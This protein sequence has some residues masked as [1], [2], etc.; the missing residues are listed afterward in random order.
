MQLIHNAYDA[1]TV[2]VIL[3]AS[4]VA[5]DTFIFR[6]A[7]PFLSIPVD[8]A[9]SV[10]AFGSTDTTEAVQTIPGGTLM[11]GESYVAIASGEVDSM[12]FSVEVFTPARMMSAGDTLVDLLAFH[13]SPDAPQVLITAQDVGAIFDPISFKEF[14]SDYTS[15]PPASYLIDVN[16]AADTSLVAT[17]EADLSGLGGGAAT[18]FASGFVTPA[19]EMDP[20]FGLWATLAD[21]TTFPLAPFVPEPDSALVQ[22]IHNAPGADT[23]SVIL[24]ANTVAIDTFVFRTAT[25]FLSIPADSSISVVGF[26]ATDTTG[27]VFTIP[28]G[29]LMDD[30]S[31]VAI[32]AGALDS[33]NI[34]VEAFAPAKML[35]DTTAVVE[36]LAFHG[37]PDAP[38]V[39]ISARN[40]GPLFEPLSFKDFSAAYTPVPPFNYVL[41]VNVAADNSPVATFLADVQTLAG[42]AITVFASGFAAPDPD[43]P[44]FGL[45]VALADGTTFPLPQADSVQ[46]QVIHNSPNP[47]VDIIL[48]P[49]GGQLDTLEDV[50]YRTATAFMTMAPGEYDIE[51]TLPDNGGS[52]FRDTV[53]LLVGGTYVAIANGQVGNEERP[54]ELALTDMAS[55]GST[56]EGFDITLFHGSQDAPTVDLGFTL[57]PALD[58]LFGIEDLEYGVFSFIPIPPEGLIF[59]TVF[60]QVID[61]ESGDVVKTFE[62][63]LPELINTTDARAAVA[64]ASGFLG[65]DAASDTAFALLAVL[66]DGQVVEFE[67]V[68]TSNEEVA[69]LVQ[70]F[71]IFPN[72]VRDQAQV[73]FNLNEAAQVMMEIFDIN[74]RRIQAES[75][76]NLP[77]GS[78]TETINT[79]SL[80]MGTYL[81][82]LRTNKGSVTARF[83]VVK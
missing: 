65:G 68:V 63:N 66:P 11:E 15:V 19:E 64:I 22:L 38:P 76:G 27:A 78:F 30:V 23:V 25:P 83:Q 8:S 53:E 58:P 56:V 18:V 9:I 6:T 20:A 50:A 29:T 3:G 79:F 48:G 35:A 10:V 73:R 33:M 47:T 13:G 49:L 43:D 40:V 12:D 54:F 52:V 37:A 57:N 51:V 16:L 21:G 2:S 1:D 74:G 14:S 34:T 39:L 81:Y 61:S 46:L 24:G 7:T 69:E 70:E 45:W 26:G 5:L 42:Q 75:Y 60:I 36:I 28:A 4:T 31:Y 17:F 77:A 71:T 55:T 41:D 62:A 67:E 82:R 44:A 72:P 32:A 59:P 80:P